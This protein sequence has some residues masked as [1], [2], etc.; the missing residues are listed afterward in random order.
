[1]FMGFS[2]NVQLILEVISD[3]EKMTVS[4]INEARNYALQ[5]AKERG[6]EKMASIDKLYS[7]LDAY[8]GY[9]D[10]FD[11]KEKDIILCMKIL[12]NRLNQI[13]FD[14]DGNKDK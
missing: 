2:P 6:A 11:F 5:V 3:C 4:V 13:E 1:M 10:K 9:I 14:L 7:C 12:Y 8:A